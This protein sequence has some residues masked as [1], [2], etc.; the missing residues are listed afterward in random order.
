MEFKK[1]E[2]MIEG[3]AWEVSKGTGV[4]VDE[5]KAQAAFIYCKTLENYDPSKA[6][7]STIFYLSLNQL[8]EYAYYFRDRKRDGTLSEIKERRIESFDYD[9]PKLKDFLNYAKKELSDKAYKIISFITGR[10]WDFVNRNKP[11]VSM[12]MREFG[13]SRD[14]A[15]SLWKECSD[16]W[17]RQGIAFYFA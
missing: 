6:N 3:K 11:N 5:L 15:K 8:W 17:N 4:D 1:Y 9:S 2:K 12:I 16:F 14:E 13:Y 7:F 10:S